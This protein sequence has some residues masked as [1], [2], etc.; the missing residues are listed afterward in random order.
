MA[1]RLTRAHPRATGE[2]SLPGASE[3][4]IPWQAGARSGSVIP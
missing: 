1:R 2:T 4:R 3:R